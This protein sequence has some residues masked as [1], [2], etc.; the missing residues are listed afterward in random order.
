MATNNIKRLM[1]L[2]ICF[3]MMVG[4]F[5]IFKVYFYFYKSSNQGQGAK[6]KPRHGKDLKDWIHLKI[7]SDYKKILDNRD[8]F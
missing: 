6:Y 8:S 2:M 7:C 5:K 3:W 4:S 1:T